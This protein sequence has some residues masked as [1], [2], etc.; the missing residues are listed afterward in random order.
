MSFRK[1]GGNSLKTAIQHSIFDPKTSAT[2]RLKYVEM[3][4]R[5]F[6]GP[7]GRPETEIDSKNAREAATM[8]RMLS[9]N[10]RRYATSIDRNGF[11]GRPINT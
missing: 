9:L 5:L 2:N 7:I 4:I 6:F 1:F 10:S 3:A 11:D 8:L